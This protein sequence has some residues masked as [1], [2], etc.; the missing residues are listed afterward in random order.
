MGSDDVKLEKLNVDRSF[1][2][3]RLLK[4]RIESFGCQI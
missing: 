1:K 4:K 2:V 3:K